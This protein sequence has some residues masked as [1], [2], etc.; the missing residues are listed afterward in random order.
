[1][2]NFTSAEIDFLQ[3]ARLGRLATIGPDGMPHV[4]PVGFRYNPDE[5]AIDIGGHGFGKSKKY[6]D[7][8]KNPRTAFVVDEVVSREPLH[9][10]GLEIRGLADVLPTGGESCGA[11]VDPEMIR[12]RANHIASW[13]INDE[14]IYAKSRSVG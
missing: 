3:Q 13:G 9:L 1:M 12:I 4:V 11:G 6:R 14:S 2:S 8:L 10:R 7:V 5:D